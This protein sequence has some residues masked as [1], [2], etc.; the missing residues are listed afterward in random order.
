[1][2]SPSDLDDSDEDLDLLEQ[3]ASSEP[4]DPSKLQTRSRDRM[5]LMQQQLCFIELNTRAK[6]KHYKNKAKL[7][8][9]HA[10]WRVKLQQQIDQQAKLRH[11]N[12]QE[13]QAKK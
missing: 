10:M 2:I 4:I 11:K 8:L 5:N 6:C 3:G 12:S 7:S 9:M 1:M 13:S